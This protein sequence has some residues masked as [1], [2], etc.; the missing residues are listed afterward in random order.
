MDDH[1]SL[2][3][4]GTARLLIAPLAALLLAVS[5]LAGPREKH[6]AERVK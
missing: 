4:H 6:E 1:A 5:V 2:A 3:R